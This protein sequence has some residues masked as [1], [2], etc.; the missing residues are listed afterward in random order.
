MTAASDPLRRRGLLIVSLPRND[1]AMA[2]AAA[3]AGAD[4]LKVHVNVHHRASGTHFGSLDDEQ[5]GLDR[6]LDV[7]LPTGLVPGE[8]AMVAPGELPRLRRFAFLDAYI[9]RLPLYLYL[10]G[11]P[12]IPAIPH[13]YPREALDA[14][15]VLPGKW[16]EASIVPPDG[17]GREPVAADLTAL[18]YVGARSRRR[19]IVPTQRAIRP[20][21]L[22]R[23]FAV[24]QVWAIMIGAMVTGRTARGVGKAAAAFRKALDALFR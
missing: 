10:A 11:V 18:A 9:T 14:L 15:A 5:E 20:E 19:M 22:S 13:D 6:V 21:D 17:Y 12:V 4:L 1:A 16:L 2:R 7:G 3:D 24:P 8:A 23:Y